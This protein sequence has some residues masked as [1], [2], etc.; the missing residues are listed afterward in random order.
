MWVN[1]IIAFQY[2]QW[3]MENVFIFIVFR[4]FTAN[5]NMERSEEIDPTRGERELVFRNYWS[6]YGHNNATQPSARPMGS[7]NHLSSLSQINNY[8]LKRVDPWHDVDTESIRYWE[9]GLDLRD[10]LGLAKLQFC[11][12]FCANCHSANFSAAGRGAERLW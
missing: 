12:K 6:Q 10:E 3:T 5:T 1:V 9:R 2:L 4:M 11:A 7:T 8:W